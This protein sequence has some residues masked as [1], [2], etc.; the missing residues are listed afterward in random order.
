MLHQHWGVLLNDFSDGKLVFMLDH[1]NTENSRHLE[2]VC[3]RLV[4]RLRDELLMGGR[5]IL[6]T[7]I[8]RVE[9]LIPC[10]YILICVLTDFTVGL[11]LNF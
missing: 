1:F 6:E 9:R 5:E 11:H 8:E 4:A 3:N 7:V 10:C 2:V